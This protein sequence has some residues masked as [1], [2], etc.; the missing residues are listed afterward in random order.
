M[1]ATA[2]LRRPEVLIMS[3]VKT[4]LLNYVC[5]WLLCLVLMFW[6]YHYVEVAEQI[7]SETIFWE[8]TAYSLLYEITWVA[9]MHFLRGALTLTTR[10]AC[11]A[12]VNFRVPFVPCQIDLLCIHNNNIVSAI[13]VRGKVGFMFSAQKAR[14]NR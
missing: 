1:R 2:V 10:I 13:N 11:V 14:Y 7:T 5:F 9:L 8:H 6:A 12:N 4:E 3:I